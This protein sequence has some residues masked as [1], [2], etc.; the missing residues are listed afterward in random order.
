MSVANTHFGT[1][2]IKEMLKDA[3]SVF[4]VGIG[5]I[6]MS[7]LAHATLLS[8]K[9]V[10]GSDRVASALTERLVK[11][12][13]QV[14]YSHCAEN[15]N[16]YDALVYTVAIS[17]DN[18]EYVAARAAGKPCISRADYMGYLMSEYVRRVGVS[19]MHGKST[20]TSMCA[21]TLMNAQADPTVMSGAELRE[22][23]GAYRIGN[24]K[25]NFLFEACEYMDSFLDF[26]PNIAVILN[27]EMDHVDYFGSMEQIIASYRSFASIAGANGKVIANGDDG[28]VIKSVEGIEP[29]VVYFGIDSKK[30]DIIAQNIRSEGGRYAFDIVAYGEYICRVELSV[31]GHHNIYNALACAAVSLEC[32]LDGEEIKKGLEAFCGAARRMEY[33][34]LLNRARVYDDYAHH[35]TEIRATLDGAKQML[36]DDGRLFC[37]FQSHTYSRTAALLD[38]FAD[39]LS[40]ADAVLVCDIYAAR[41]VNSFGV[42]P[43]SL[44]EKINGARACHGFDEPARILKCEL[45]GGDVAIIMG[46]G[47][48]WRIFE[49]LELKK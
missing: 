22:M 38:D 4:F 36:G 28:K 35:P 42:T 2:K 48:V 25:D 31:S 18:P 44:A 17:E 6:N 13:A 5:G 49:R 9:R 15:V 34:G 12:G 32:G 46:A 39:A 30:A 10:G 41:E 43:E 16:D 29:E 23:G 33:K 8:G 37:V 26:N 21:L 11:A 3:H 19:G 27:I 24:N 47:D 40:V 14:F 45:R 7:S 20:C 1:K